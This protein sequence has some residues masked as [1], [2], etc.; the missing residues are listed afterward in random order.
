[1][2]ELRKHVLPRFTRPGPTLLT[3]FHVSAKSSLLNSVTFGEKIDD[4]SSFEDEG[5]SVSSGCFVV[6]NI[7]ADLLFFF[8]LVA[9]KGIYLAFS[10]SKYL[11]GDAA[12]TKL[13]LCRINCLQE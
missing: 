9:F 10:C 11:S 8:F 6:G 7:L 3:L 12:G 4:S 2:T 5:E 1:M 13:I